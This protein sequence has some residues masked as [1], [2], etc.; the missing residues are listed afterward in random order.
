MKV[1]GSGAGGRRRR[2]RTCY[3]R[4]QHH[5]ITT[6]L[7][8]TPTC[9]LSH[10]TAQRRGGRHWHINPQ[11]RAYACFYDGRRS[12]C[13]YGATERERW[14]GENAGEDGIAAEIPVADGGQRHN[15]VVSSI[16]YLGK[17][18]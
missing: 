17:E 11:W 10:Y 18:R 4:T 12:V 14:G 2:S 5:C 15:D 1:T 7:L 3:L 9:L 13:D 6:C 8:F 16:A